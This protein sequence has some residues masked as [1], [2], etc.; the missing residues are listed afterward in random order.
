MDSLEAADQIKNVFFHICF[1]IGAKG[2]TREKEVLGSDGGGGEAWLNLQFDK[3][4]RRIAIL[5]DAWK[6]YISY[7]TEGRSF[8]CLCGPAGE[9]R[10]PSLEQ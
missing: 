3:I 2:Q 6:I 9:G 5:K 4:Q 7:F 1:Q 10:D 8:L